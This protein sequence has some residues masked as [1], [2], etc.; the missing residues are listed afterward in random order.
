MS[1]NVRIDNSVV[2][3]CRVSTDAQDKSGLGLEAQL[4]LCREVSVR[5]GKV[6]IGEF[7]EQVSG[8]VDPKLRPIFE[9]ARKLAVKS[10]ASMMVA[11]LDRFSREVYHVAGYTQNY[12]FGKDTPPL[13]VAESPSMSQLEIYIKAMISEEERKLIAKRTRDALA[14]LKERGAQLGK[15]GREVAHAKYQ[16]ANEPSVLRA[17][18]LRTEGYSYARIADFLNQEGFTTSMGGAWYPAEIRK[19][20]L[21]YQNKG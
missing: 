9:D 1:K 3:Y 8:K 21:V 16:E 6:V 2:I 13:I 14:I 19:R 12:S 15:A 17:I 4:Q 11:R 18:E 20:M 10:G 7:R 5:L